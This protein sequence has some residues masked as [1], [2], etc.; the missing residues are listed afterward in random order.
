MPDDAP[1]DRST[2]PLHTVVHGG[3]SIRGAR[4]DAIRE[5]QS[6]HEEEARACGGVVRRTVVHGVLMRVPGPTTAG[7][8]AP[9]LAT[10][11]DADRA[12]RSAV[13]AHSSSSSLVG[14]G[15]VALV[16]VAALIALF[17]GHTWR[18]RRGDGY[19]ELSST[20]VE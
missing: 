19:A 16:A 3:R 15:A 14:T 6:A 4:G 8:S 7:A 10:R 12:D 17:A 5:A 18:Q 20:P 9:A 13:I 11:T 2:S 1:T